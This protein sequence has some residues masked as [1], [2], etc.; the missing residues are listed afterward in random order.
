M[1][2]NDRYPFFA[3]GGPFGEIDTQTFKVGIHEMDFAVKGL[4]A[5]ND[6]SQTDNT[7]ITYKTRNM[8]ADLVRY[9]MVDPTR[10]GLATNTWAT[11]YGQTFELIDDEPQYFV[12]VL[13]RVRARLD[14]DN[15]YELA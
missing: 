11:D 10:G 5:Y 3:V 14:T 6:E 1:N 2:V 7:E 4:V 15:P 13:F 8:I 9:V 12:Y